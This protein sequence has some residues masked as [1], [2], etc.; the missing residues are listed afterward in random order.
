[1]QLVEWRGVEPG[2]MKLM[3]KAMSIGTIPVNKAQMQQ[4]AIF[5]LADRSNGSDDQSLIDFVREN[6]A[7]F[8]RYSLIDYPQGGPGHMKLVFNGRG[9]RRTKRARKMKLRKTY[10]KASRKATHKASR[11]ANPKTIRKTYR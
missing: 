7:M 1:M 9:G 10:R 4:Q 5:N 8:E 2:S 6:P 3:H 11:K